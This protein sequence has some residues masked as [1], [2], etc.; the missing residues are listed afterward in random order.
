MILL[1][2]VHW[3]NQT[4]FMEVIACIK[5]INMAGCASHAGKSSVQGMLMQGPQLV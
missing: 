2:A 4:F 5:L 1:D 3:R